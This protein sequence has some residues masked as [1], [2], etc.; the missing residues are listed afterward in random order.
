MLGSKVK[1]GEVSNVLGCRED[2]TVGIDEVELVG[3]ELVTMVGSTL[4]IKLGF[5]DGC[6]D[7]D[8]G[9]F[10]EWKLRAPYQRPFSSNFIGIQ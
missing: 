1:A 4:G 10:G 9:K 7:M 3:F 6:I 2:N 5:I 8:E